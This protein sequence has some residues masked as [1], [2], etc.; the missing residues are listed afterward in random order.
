MATSLRVPASSPDHGP[1]AA[2]RCGVGPV[3]VLLADRETLVLEALRAFLAPGHRVVGCARDG[4][5]LVEQALRLQPDLVVSELRLPGLDGLEAA[6]RVL[7]SCRRVRFVFLTSVEDEA[8]AEQAFAAGASGFLLKSS[9]GAE[10]VAGLREVMQGGRVLSRC[11]ASG[12]PEA[13][14]RSRGSAGRDGRGPLSPR[15]AE[16]VRLLALGHS[17]KQA[18]YEL[19]ITPRTVAYHKY[20]AMHVLGIGSSAEL[21][22]FA[23]RTGML[24]SLELAAGA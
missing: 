8:Q 10:F 18:A 23:V 9:S 14:A 24:E 19:G 20:G 17:M 15:T 2:G 4:I 7:E 22:R 5:A 12:R 6:R 21:V 3:R 11:I 16:V 13:L 1:R